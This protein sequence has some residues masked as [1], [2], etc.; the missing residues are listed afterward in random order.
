LQIPKTPTEWKQIAKG[1][2]KQWQFPN[3]LG[4]LDGKHVAIKKPPHSGSLYYNYKNFFSIVM[5]AVVSSNYEFIIVDVGTNGRVS[6]GGVLANSKFGQLL[7]KN[8]LQTPQPERLPNSEKTL[9]FVSVADDAFAMSENLLKPY[10]QTGLTPEQRIFNYRL[11]RA[12]CIVENA[13]GIL[14]SRFGVFQRPIAVSPEKADT[15]I[16]A[17]CYLHN[18]LMKMKSPTYSYAG[19]TDTENHETHNII[20][21]SWRQ[22]GELTTLKNCHSRNPSANAKAV[23]DS[24]C[25]YFNNEGKVSWQNKFC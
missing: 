2:Y 17:C 4:A 13:F 24:F 10:S 18:Y 3:C 9:P 12:R 6:D 19:L 16:L 21:G 8:S 14:N 23:R 15:I 22:S 20:E 7:N 11:S 5:L 1:F 25:H